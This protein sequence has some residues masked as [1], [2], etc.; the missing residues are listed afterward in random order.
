M[1][2]HVGEA[3]PRVNGSTYHNETEKRTTRALRAHTPRNDLYLLHEHYT[4]QPAEW[5]GSVNHRHTE[6]KMHDL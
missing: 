5:V 6:G 4:S 1:H 2:V 3:K